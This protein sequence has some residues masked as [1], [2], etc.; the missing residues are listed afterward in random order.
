MTVPVVLQYETPGACFMKI[1]GRR[2]N[3]FFALAEV[4]WILSG[5]GNV[6]WI[7]FFNSNMR[8]FADE[9]Q[10][11]FHGAYGKRIRD[12]RGSYVGHSIYVDQI[13]AVCN[14]LKED[15]FSRQAIISLWDPISD[16]KPE[17]NDYPCNNWVA[18][19]LR[20]GKL[21][22]SVAIRS[23][24][25]IWGTPYNAVQF[26]HLLALVAGNLGV[27]CGA[28][29][30]FVQNL[31]VYAEYEGRGTIHDAIL[32]HPSDTNQ[33][34]ALGSVVRS[35]GV[36]GLVACKISSFEPISD[37]KLKPT[38]DYVNQLVEAYG[39]GNLVDPLHYAN[40]LP[41]V[42]YWG[43]LIP[44]M[45]LIYCSVKTGAVFTPDQYAWLMGSIASLPELFK[46]LVLDFYKGQ[47]DKNPLAKEIVL[48][49][50]KEEP[51]HVG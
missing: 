40:I 38:I 41:G 25:I 28:I 4:I 34:D 24:D 47:I 27:Q 15:P 30:Y 21:N 6:E 23:N 26:T 51:N 49:F 16:N 3:I 1:P 43:L 33:S 46:W 10:P 42:G 17:S 9:G 22:M 50:R 32:I 7:S 36:Q 20:D 44:K 13:E 19:S 45:L 18:F 12:C 31:H 39:K 37:E 2:F 5:N 8:K 11:D 29:T 35:V 14:K 48:K